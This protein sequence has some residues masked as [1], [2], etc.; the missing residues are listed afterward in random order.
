MESSCF[1]KELFSPYCPLFVP[2]MQ[3]E[4]AILFFSRTLEDEYKAKSFGLSK[5]RFKSVYSGLVSKA[6][7]VAQQT[8]FALHEVYSGSQVGRTFGERLINAIRS[9]ESGGFKKVLVIGND[10][11][12]L[13]ALHLKQAAQ[14]LGNHPSVVLEDKRGGIAL[15]GIDLTKVDFNDLI[16]IKW[17]TA[18]VAQ[19]LKSRVKSYSLEWSLRDVNSK[20]DLL[21]LRREASKGVRKFVRLLCAAFTNTYQRIFE[22]TIEVL[23]ACMLAFWKGP[24]FCL[25]N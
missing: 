15:L 4:T 24:P 2:N 25:L 3:S 17:S 11:P 9:I 14:S 8:G 1:C 12:E 20:R 19:E 7:R 5:E 13:N 10:C 16:S 23:R 18:A 22:Q 6:L 21:L